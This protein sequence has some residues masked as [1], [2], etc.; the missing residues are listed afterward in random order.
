MYPAAPSSSQQKDISIFFEVIC[1]LIHHLFPIRKRQKE[2][3]KWLYP[4][5]CI[6]DG[7]VRG[8]SLLWRRH[9]REKMDYF[10][11]LFC[12]GWSR[13]ILLSNSQSPR[14]LCYKRK[15]KE[16]EYTCMELP[17]NCLTADWRLVHNFSS[18]SQTPPFNRQ[19]KSQIIQIRSETTRITLSTCP[20]ITLKGF[21]LLRRKTRTLDGQLPDL[22]F[23]YHPTQFNQ[24]AI[25]N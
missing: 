22:D 13:S 10:F 21:K 3:K 2:I 12:S 16:S 7:V 8:F 15:K 4:V 11:F 6:S 1:M 18:M 25:K 24:I 19:L 5:E 23:R 9:P 14:F 20:C 17:L